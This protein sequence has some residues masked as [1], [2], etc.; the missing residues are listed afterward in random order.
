[1]E[2]GS[3][4]FESYE[5]D[6]AA[7]AQAIQ[8]KLYHDLPKLKGEQRETILRVTDRELAEAEE[9]VNQMEIEVFN[10]PQFSQ[11]RI[12][13]RLESYRA[14]LQRLKRDVKRVIHNFPNAYEYTTTSEDYDAGN[15]S[16]R[17]HLLSGY[18]RVVDA[19]RRLDNANRIAVET[20]SIGAGVLGA[21][22]QQREQI[23]FTQ[24]ELGQADV[25]LE[26]AHRTIRGI[27]WRAATNRMISSVILLAVVALIGLIVYSKIA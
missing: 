11:P 20:E 21:L 13:A 9:I 5:L 6:Y 8:T 25:E 3:E 24:Q 22:R 19:N 27:A 15:F 10:V 2:A 12:N 7:I 14:D 23:Q 16:Q 26:R 18:H 4:L 1:M 17:A